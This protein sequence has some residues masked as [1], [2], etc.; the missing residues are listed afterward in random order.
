MRYTHYGVGHSAMMRKVVKDCSESVTLPNIDEDVD[1]EV[2]DD[3]DGYDE[4][5]DEQ[6]DDDECDDDDDDDDDD[7]ELDGGVGDDSD[8]GGDDEFDNHISF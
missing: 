1:H 5:N 6:E 2:V 3:G 4:C 7:G 8:D